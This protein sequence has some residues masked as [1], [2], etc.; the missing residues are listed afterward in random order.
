MSWC[1]YLL[2]TC[3]GGSKRTYVGAS[4]DVDRRLR[5]HNGLQSGGAKATHG[6]QWNRVC[7]LRGFPSERAA[8]Q[9]EWALKY[10]SR[11]EVGNPVQ[12]RLRALVKLMYGTT[13]TKKALDYESYKYTLDFIWEVEGCCIDYLD[14]LNILLDNTT[15]KQNG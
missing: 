15:T 11:K 12:R 9:F 4:L 7:H 5:Q 3:D 13:L 1:V 8:L 14:D 10:R 6:R 2:Q